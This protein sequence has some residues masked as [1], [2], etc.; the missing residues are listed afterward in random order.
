MNQIEVLERGDKHIP[1]EDTRIA[2]YTCVKCNSVLDIPY[3]T[4][5]KS[6]R[7]I[8]GVTTCQCLVCY[9]NLYRPK[10]L[11]LLS[12][13][14]TWPIVL[15]F[16]LFEFIFENLLPCL[17]IIIIIAIILFMIFSPPPQHQ[18]NISDCPTNSKHNSI[19]A[20]QPVQ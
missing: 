16:K 11:V 6:K 19:H 7:H 14:V 1:K 3:S 17:T 13:I 18:C 15:I 10:L 5:K 12:N 9:D 2:R 4:W 20:V 8:F